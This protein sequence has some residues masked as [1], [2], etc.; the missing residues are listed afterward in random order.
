[1]GRSTLAKV[2]VREDT[3]AMLSAFSK[4]STGAV[5]DHVP[6][7]ECASLARAADR[8]AALVATERSSIAVGRRR[9]V[10]KQ[11]RPCEVGCE[12]S[13]VRPGAVVQAG[14]QLPETTCFAGDTN[15]ARS[16]MA[17]SG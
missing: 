10:G 4:M 12:A 15:A 2:C 1:M 7:S 17:Q 5:L 14:R 11:P 6:D 13:V 9:L 3:D 16:D 8:T